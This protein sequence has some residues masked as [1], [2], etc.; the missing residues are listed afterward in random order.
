MPLSLAGNGVR[1]MPPITGVVGHVAWV[2]ERGD[3]SHD[4]VQAKRSTSD[5]IH[6][7][8]SSGSHSHN[9]QGHTKWVTFH[10]TTHHRP[11]T[12]HITTKLAATSQG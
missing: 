10:Q 1:W 3:T 2:G 12:A 5:V 9:V 8:T 6:I 7:V 4:Q 11:D